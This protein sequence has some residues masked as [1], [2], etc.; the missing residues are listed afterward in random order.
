MMK[1]IILFT[2][3]GISLADSLIPFFAWSPQAW[4]N[5]AH[6]VVPDSVSTADVN[7]FIRQAVGGPV[8]VS[9]LSEYTSKTVPKPEVL[10]A[11]IHTKLSPSDVSRGSGAYVSSSSSAS[12]STSR[13]ASLSST[14]SSSSWSLTVPSVMVNTHSGALSTVLSNAVMAA[15]ISA[16][17]LA[18][19]LDS[20]SVSV[21]GVAGCDALVAQLDDIDNGIFQ[22]GRTDLIL[23]Q[24]DTN[25]NYD[26]CMNRLVDRVNKRSNGAYLAILSA[27]QSSVDPTATFSRRPSATNL[28]DISKI[29]LQADQLF[30]TLAGTPG[31]GTV[32]TGGVRASYYPGVTM[33][34]SDL[35]F[36]LL[37]LLLLI[38]ILLLGIT[39]TMSIETPTRFAHAPL[40]LSKEY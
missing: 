35:F 7:A 26:A 40:Q 14:L 39:C 30:H 34:T 6:T 15:D 24:I 16:S 36:A 33:L 38:F 10:L 22:N 25:E 37:L 1:A 2:L 11:F 21:K 29:S 18:T 13:F 9:G 17:V 20:S 32:P 27:D 8:Q 5:T 28:L 31:N 12:S 23:V 3:I 4:S 19:K